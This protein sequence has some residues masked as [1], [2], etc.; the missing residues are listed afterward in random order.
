MRV[1]QQ[2]I[3]AEKNPDR[4][5]QQQNYADDPHEAGARSARQKQRVRF[6]SNRVAR[7]ALEPSVSETFGQL[8]ST[9]CGPEDQRAKNRQHEHE[10][11]KL[12]IEREIEKVKRQAARKNLVLPSVGR[13]R[14]S[15]RP[16]KPH[17]RP[18]VDRVRREYD[19]HE[20]QPERNQTRVHA[21]ILPMNAGKSQPGGVSRP[22]RE[23]R[24]H[25]ARR[26]GGNAVP[27]HSDPG[28]N[29]SDLFPPIV[30]NDEIGGRR[31]RPCEDP[32]QKH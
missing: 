11:E 9:S 17:D 25:G 24:H 4:E 28:V 14:E 27:Q 1:Q 8:P 12:R 26:R 3:V 20:R 18:V 6:K 15:A 7:P 5:S 29:L 30:F 10:S 16:E 13:G 21:E 2:L 31:R 32:E 19:R 22:Q 23:K